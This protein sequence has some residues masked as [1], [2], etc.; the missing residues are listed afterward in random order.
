MNPSDGTW[1]VVSAVAAIVG[2]CGTLAAVAVAAFAAWFTF[3][4]WCDLF[5][6]AFTAVESDNAVEMTAKVHN[7]GRG[8]ALEARWTLLRYEGMENFNHPTKYLG[9]LFPDETRP[10]KHTVQLHRPVEQMQAPRYE[11]LLRWDTLFGIYGETFIET[12][13]IRTDRKRIAV[14]WSW[15]RRPA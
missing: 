7:A 1:A 14:K 3:M 12:G 15:R 2:A 4:P 11:M 5:D 8:Q 9:P 10:V 6:V 13:N